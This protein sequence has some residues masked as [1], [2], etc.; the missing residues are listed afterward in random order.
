MDFFDLGF[1][2]YLS[3]AERCGMS[4]FGLMKSERRIYWGTI[5]MGGH[6]AQFEIVPMTF[7]EVQDLKWLERMLENHGL[8]MHYA[9]GTA[10]YEI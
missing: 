6:A 5:N 1:E 8:Q 9:V 4:G 3:L 10:K 2:P 7:E